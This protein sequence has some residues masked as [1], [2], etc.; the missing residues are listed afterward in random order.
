MT[1]K[2]YEVSLELFEG[3]LDLLLFLVKKNDLDINN[4]P[5]AEITKEYLSY[6][7]LMKD[8]DLD[9]AGDFLVMAATLMAVKSRSLL[10][11]EQAALEGDEGPNPAAELAQKLIE[12]QK[13]KEASKFLA[14]RADE[15]AGV[16]YRGAPHFE[17]AEKSPNVSLFD[18]MAHLQV[19]LAGA[20]DDSQSVE[21]EEFPIEEKMEKILFLLSERPMIPWEELFADERKR[22]GII[23]CFLAMLELTKLQ[24]IFIRQEGTFGK[25]S[26]FRKDDAPV[27]EVPVAETP[28][29]EPPAVADA[30][31]AAPVDN[32]GETDVQP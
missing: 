29:A 2:A 13:F 5:I 22:R 17:E 26:I 9:I 16:F 25:I 3:P 31:N 27:E 32:P 15:M 4:I 23:A 21:G 6:L 11:S 18:L 7:E 1:E 8:M 10:P 30:G 12:Y 19:I 24:K 14:G 20:E 28:I